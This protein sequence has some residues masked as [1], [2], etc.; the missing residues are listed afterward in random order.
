[1]F[2]LNLLLFLVSLSLLIFVHELGHFTFAKIFGVYCHEFSLGMGPAIVKKKFKKDKETTYS[3][4]ALPIGGYV[5]MAG[6]A[7]ESE[8]DISIP[9]E[10]TIN[11]IKAWKRAIVVV[12]GATVNFLFALLLIFIV[13][14]GGGL[15]TPKEGYV[16]VTKDSVAYIAGLRD[17]DFITS[18]RISGYTNSIC[19]IA[20]SIESSEQLF[21]YLSNSSPKEIGQIQTIEI[22]YIRGSVLDNVVVNRSF[23]EENQQST[24]IGI[25][26]SLEA[27]HPGFFEGIKLSFMKFGEVIGSMFGAI[28]KLFTKEG[29]NQVGGPIQIYKVSSQQASQGV[30]PYIWF[31]AIL[32][33]NLG[34]FNLFPIPGLDGSRFLVSVFEAITNKKVNIKVEGYLNAVGIIFLLSVMLLV[35]IKDIVGL[36]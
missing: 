27:Y 28:G 23:D 2:I 14:F 33:I 22:E 34:I 16:K 19:E 7:V 15:T 8:K 17:E 29:I 26:M 11:G 35:T 1:M 18:I 13:T 9:F 25:A 36:F 21:N 3:L 20:C 24:L 12:A 6:E 30:L 32:S 31:L 10:R 4:R 5:A